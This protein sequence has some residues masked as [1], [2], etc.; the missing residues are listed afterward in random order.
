MAD[1][2]KL[3]QLVVEIA[4]DLKDLRRG[5]TETKNVLEGM[6]K[7][8]QR[9]AQQIQS[10]F[11][12][13]SGRLGALVAGY[14]S[15]QKAV[16]TFNQNIDDI[17]ALGRLSQTTGIAVGTLSA[18][19]RIAQEN[20]VEFS[21]FSQVVSQFGTRLTEALI[22]PTSKAGGAIERLGLQLRDGQGNLRNFADLL[23]DIADKFAS[24]TDGAAKAQTAAALFGEEAGPRMVPFL[25]RGR[26]AIEEQIRV[27]TE[28]GQ[29]ITR[30][31]VQK[32]EDYR[33]AL[34]RLDAATTSFGRE[35]TL[36][37][38]GPL[39][40]VTNAM[41]DFLGAVRK[42]ATLP[43][44]STEESQAQIKRLNERIV[45]LNKL[46]ETQGTLRPRMAE[47]WRAE[48]EA[49]RAAVAKIEESFTRVSASD[50]FRPPPED[51][52]QR[53]EAIRAAAAQVAL[54]QE[55]MAG[56]VPLLQQLLFG[57][58]PEGARGIAQSFIDALSQTEAAMQRQGQTAK[59][60]AAQKRQLA[61]TEQGHILDT[62][63][64]AAS[65]LTAVFAKSKGAAIGSAIIN[66]GV[67]ITKALQLP[68]PYNWIQA[69]LIAAS[70]AAQIASI[71]SAN[72]S[73]GGAVAG[74][75]STGS[76]ESVEPEAP[77][78][79]LFI[80]GVDPGAIFGGKQ[81][82]ELIKSINNEVQNGATLISTRNIRT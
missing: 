31:G 8:S 64:L 59:Q 49:A 41:T 77:G 82:E 20:G 68:T 23:P 74:T 3:G 7:Q 17:S 37:A 58:D 29:V 56:Q 34:S 48:I 70:G 2:V 42:A 32:A 50:V 46:I 22:N 25:N 1:S 60:I 15:A 30:E 19:Q 61:M 27:L 16:A 78:R 24:W 14:I 40:S 55:Q 35:L 76:G 4:A 33:R 81:L 71:R 80:Q 6:G 65:T 67:A 11:G 79:S 13:I 43:P 47:G 44:I 63:S 5:Q 72:P 73:G 53:Q 66:T 62:A 10:S 45:E 51:E 36:L 57:T 9:A 12:F 39:T 18:L 52:A 69:G 75:G 54:I 26:A 38:A 21:N 28:S